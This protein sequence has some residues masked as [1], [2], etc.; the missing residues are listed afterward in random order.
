MKEEEEKCS[1]TRM[2]MSSRIKRIK[3]GGEGQGLRKTFLSKLL[4]VNRIKSAKLLFKSSKVSTRSKF[5]KLILICIETRFGLSPSSDSLF[6]CNSA[7][8]APLAVTVHLQCQVYQIK[9]HKIR[10]RRL[11]SKL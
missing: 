5:S 11:I 2:S 4:V 8:A 3:K 7:G 9:S 1:L 6:H 10:N